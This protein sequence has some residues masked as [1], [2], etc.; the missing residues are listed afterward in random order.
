MVVCNHLYNSNVKLRLLSRMR[1]DALFYSD[2]Y[3]YLLLDIAWWLAHLD[4]ILRFLWCNIPNIWARQR[5]GRCNP[6]LNR[7]T[8]HPPLAEP[9]ALKNEKENVLATQSLAFEFKMDRCSTLIRFYLVL[10]IFGDAMKKETH[11]RGCGIVTLC[12]ITQLYHIRI[13]K[14]LFYI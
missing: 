8:P 14:D 10:G 3:Q 4:I 11:G 2:L 12:H 7:Q 13:I 9:I 6:D 5:L 1:L